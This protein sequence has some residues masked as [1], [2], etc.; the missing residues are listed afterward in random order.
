MAKAGRKSYVSYRKYCNTL[1]DLLRMAEEDY[2][3]KRLESLKK[4]QKRNWT[5]LKAL[6]GRNTIA[7]SDHFIIDGVEV[8]DP[9]TIANEFCNYFVNHPKHIQGDIPSSHNN[10]TENMPLY[11]YRFILDLVT[12]DEVNLCY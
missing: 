11:N 1:R 10:Y 5:V 2:H 7:I 3:V 9:L 4:D 12:S 6:L 8:N